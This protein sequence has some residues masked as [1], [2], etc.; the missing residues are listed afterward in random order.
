[1]TRLKFLPLILFCTSLSIHSSSQPQIKLS[2]QNRFQTD[3]EKVINDYPNFFN[4]IKGEEIS[5]DFQST[6]YRSTIILNG[7]EECT[8]TKYSAK[9][10][11]IYSWRA[12][13]LTT[14]SFDAAKKKFKTLYNEINNI[15][16]HFNSKQF[17]FKGKFETPVEEKSFNTIIFSAEPLD[18]SVK[19]PKVELTMEYELSSWKIKIL[20][21]GK[22]RND[23]EKG[24]ST[25]D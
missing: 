17:H 5:A 20:V 14:E 18:E 10:K 9:K 24:E 13:M 16:V 12:I 21:Y 4:K 1:M 22:E 8:I 2:F 3:L 19:S 25:E 15:P 7:A 11:E 23:D 6:D